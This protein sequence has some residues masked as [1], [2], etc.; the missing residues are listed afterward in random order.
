MKHR[1]ELLTQ[2]MK[3][4]QEVQGK[5]TECLHYFVLQNFQ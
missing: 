4:V 5:P 1:L 3:E 2:M